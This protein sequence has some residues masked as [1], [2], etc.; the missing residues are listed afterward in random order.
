[1]TVTVNC[2]YS[3]STDDALLIAGMS[4]YD[5][6]TRRDMVGAVLVK[7]AQR[8]QEACHL[9]WLRRPNMDLTA[10]PQSKAEKIIFGDHIRTIKVLRKWFKSNNL[11]VPEH[12]DYPEYPYGVVIA[13]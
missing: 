7:Q 9:V 12:Q 3:M 10:P 13:E 8:Y 4:Q 1:M 6:E 5:L 2:E 11:A